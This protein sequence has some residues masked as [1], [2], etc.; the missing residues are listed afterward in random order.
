MIF[1]QMIEWWF[2]QLNSIIFKPRRCMV[3][4]VEFNYNQQSRSQITRLRLVFMGGSHLMPFFTYP[5]NYKSSNAQVYTQTANMDELGTC[6]HNTSYFHVRSSW[7]QH[8]CCNSV[9]L[10]FWKVVVLRHWTQQTVLSFFTAMDSQQICYMY[11]YFFCL[12]VELSC[13][14]LELILSFHLF[15]FSAKKKKNSCSKMLNWK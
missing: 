11:I 13:Q 3:S 12:I 6:G 7:L 14:A 10:Q 9:K 4:T 15:L 8:V 1:Y 2:V 5:L